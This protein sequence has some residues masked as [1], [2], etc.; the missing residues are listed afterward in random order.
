MVLSAVLVKADPL[1]APPRALLVLLHGLGMRPE[2]LAPFPQALALPVVSAV[3]PGPVVHADGSRAWWPVD[4]A[5]RRLRLADP[6]HGPADLVDRRPA[7]R[8][9]AR[10]VLAAEL[11]RLRSTWPDLPLVLA[12]FSQ[13][14]MLA[15]D[16][17]LGQDDGLPVQGLVLMSSSR[18]AAV[19]WACRWP[20]VAGLP[21]L[22]AHG[23]QDADLSFAAGEGLRNAL[24]AAGAQ[25]QWLPFDGGH[26]IP[27]IVW[28]ALRR[29][30][31]QR[32][33]EQCT[34]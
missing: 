10:A 23:R 19:D 29:F 4:L 7:G 31:L 14:G 5:A 9:A 17:L 28:R 12:G 24:E 20:R 18:I 15:L 6:A 21:V 32:S 33:A 22:V 34:D 8:E 2:V 3:P 16:H 13:G 30:V 27:L 26:E 25:V 11:A 1:V